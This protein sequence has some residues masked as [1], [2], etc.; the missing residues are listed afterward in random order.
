MKINQ[1]DKIAV[2]ELVG[3]LMFIDIDVPN[4]HMDI[5][6]TICEDEDGKNWEIR[7]TYKCKYN[8]YYDD[9]FVEVIDRKL[10]STLDEFCRLERDKSET[11]KYEH[12]LYKKQVN[13]DTKNSYFL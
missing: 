3:N 12:E 4:N 11:E 13:E 9:E 5:I 6:L 1:L 2:L 10:E 8:L 7:G